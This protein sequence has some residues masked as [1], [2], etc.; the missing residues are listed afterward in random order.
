MPKPDATYELFVAGDLV[1]ATDDFLEL[2]ER[3]EE[4]VDEHCRADVEARRDGQAFQPGPSRL[5]KRF[6]FGG[7]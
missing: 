4:A 1:L 6:S 2:S 7:H 3:Y 5:A